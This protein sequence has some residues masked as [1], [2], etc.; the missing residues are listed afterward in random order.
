MHS[1]EIN[2]LSTIYLFISYSIILFVV[3]LCIIGVYLNVCVFIVFMCRVYVEVI[4]RVMCVCIV[5]SNLNQPF[6]TRQVDSIQ[7]TKTTCSM[8]VVCRDLQVCE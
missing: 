1:L 7:I 3:V 5:L 8:Y 6:L 4:E 2:V